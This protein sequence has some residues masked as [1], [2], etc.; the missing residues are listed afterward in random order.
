MRY[1]EA[2]DAVIVGGGHAGI[3]A[4]LA[5]ARNGLKTMLVT[6]TIDSVGR[7]SCNPSVGGIAKGNIVREVDALGGE[8]AKL[9]DAAMIQFRMLNKSKGPAVQAPR[10]QADKAL[11]AALARQTLESCPNLHILQDTVTDIE[12]QEG[13]SLPPAPRH[14]L[15]AVVTE[16]GRKIPCRACVL[17]T[18]TFLGGKIFIGEYDA[19]Q[20]RLGEGAAF[21]LTGALKR[22]G[23][24]TG[25]L[26]TGT[27]PRVLKKSIDFSRLESQE[28]DTPALPFSFDT[29]EISRPMVPCHIVYTNSETHRIIRENLPRSPLFSGKISGTGPRYCPSIEDKVVRFAERERHQLFVEPEGLS[30]DEV[31]LN[32]FSSSLPEDAQDKFLRTLPGFERAIITRPAYA[33]EY[34]YIDPTQLF[35]SLETK[36]VAGLFTAGQINGTSGY[37]EAAGQGIIAGIN[38]ARYAKAVMSSELGVLSQKQTHSPLNP[39]SS[40]LNPTPCP[41]PPAPYLPLILRR[42]EAYIGVLI[43]DLVTLGTAEPYRMFTARAE[44]RLKL[45]HDTADIRLAQKGF[46]SGLKTRGQ[47]EAVQKKIAL[48]AEIAALLEKSDSAG[49]SALAQS[50]PPDI[51]EA[52]T[53]DK[54]YE[55][56]IKKQDARIE[57][58]KRIENARIPQSFDYKTVTG[59][60]SE[61]LQKLEKIR[62]LTLGQASRISGVRSSDIMLLMT[63]LPVPAAN[64]RAF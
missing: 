60:S 38:A 7:M 1:G 58:L 5:C 31:Y 37:E 2:F 3:E 55:H 17:T 45:R 56:Y 10:A 24:V 43:D 12:V 14:I 48:K 41:L 20:G 35:P 51:V 11:Y 42:D 27:P 15:K 61:S 62:P 54:K 6:Q 4:A 28:G 44:Y 64:R 39:Q 13:E 36:P 8:M 23:F 22:L 25:R 52:A 21:G 34:D 50:Y 63:H 53:L 29:R 40:I 9:A 49:A 16:R 57:K 47:L 26:K 30:T 59:L 18:G 33:V 46:E 19:P 32:G